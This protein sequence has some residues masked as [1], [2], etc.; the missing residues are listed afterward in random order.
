MPERFTRAERRAIMARVKAKNTRPEQAV[1]T[2]L[3]ALQIPFRRHRQS[4]PGNP[5]FVVS[6]ARAV[7]FVHGCFWHQHTCRRGRLRPVSNAAYWSAK[8]NRNVTRDRASV[9]K[10]R[11]LGWRVLTIWECRLGRASL[12]KRIARFLAA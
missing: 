9:R 3:R 4:L 8:L 2:L 5:D 11:R 1:A 6:S 10:L 7:I 12:Q